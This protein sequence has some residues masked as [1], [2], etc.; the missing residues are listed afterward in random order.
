MGSDVCARITYLSEVFWND[1][2][3]L[4]PMKA[5]HSLSELCIVIVTSTKLLAKLRSLPI[6][7]AEIALDQPLSNNLNAKKQFP[8]S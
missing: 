7:L 6:D 5:L 1:V 3:I 4:K 2:V 8:F